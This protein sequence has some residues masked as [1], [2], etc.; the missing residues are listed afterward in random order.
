MKCLKERFI[1]ND[2]IFWKRLYTAFMSVIFSKYD[3]GH[4]NQF[5][6]LKSVISKLSNAVWN[7]WKSLNKLFYLW[8]KINDHFELLSFFIIIESMIFNYFKS[9]FYYVFRSDS[10]RHWKRHSKNVLGTIRRIGVNLLMEHFLDIDH[11][12]KQ[13]PNC[14]HLRLCLAVLQDCLLSSTHT[15]S[16]Q[17]L[18][19]IRHMRRCKQF[20]RSYA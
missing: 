7:W 11:P 12:N 16:F 13:A 15:R 10:M 14:L 18:Q 3:N 19:L 20:A 5:F 2:A 1:N 6:I 17:M 8:L 4:Q 9:S